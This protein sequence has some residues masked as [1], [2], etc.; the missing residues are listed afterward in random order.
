MR[1]KIII[2]MPSQ[3]SQL[4]FSTESVS[5]ELNRPTRDSDSSRSGPRQI[6]LG[7]LVSDSAESLN[8]DGHR[9]A[10][11]G[12]INNTLW[13]TINSKKYIENKTDVFNACLWY[14]CPTRYD[15]MVEVSVL[16]SLQI[17]PSFT[18]QYQNLIRTRAKPVP[19]NCKFTLNITGKG[20]GVTEKIWCK[21]QVIRMTKSMFPH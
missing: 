11:T 2:I 15:S 14:V 13:H 20:S 18:C 5:S 19:G 3:P 17:N 8:R 4:R 9:Y 1:H 6:R 12:T 21:K 7:R 10:D 16:P